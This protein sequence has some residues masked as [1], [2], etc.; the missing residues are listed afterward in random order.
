MTATALPGE[1]AELERFGEWMLPNERAR[2]NKRVTSTMAE[3]QAFYDGVFPHLDAAAAYLE[4]IAMD[5]LSDE[6]K[7]LLWLCSSLVTVS[8][9]VECWRQPRVPDSGAA[10]FDEVLA[11]PI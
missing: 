8:F 10:T 1:F 2:Y 5:E 3:L 11:P 6:D 7:H 9:A 4:R